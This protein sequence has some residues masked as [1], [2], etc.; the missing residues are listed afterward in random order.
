MQNL[1]E[2]TSQVPDS[3]QTNNNLQNGTIVVREGRDWSRPSSIR[4]PGK[5]GQRNSKLPFRKTQLQ[6]CCTKIDIVP[7]MAELRYYVD[8]ES[9]YMVQIKSHYPGRVSYI[10]NFSFHFTHLIS[11][12]V[13]WYSKSDVRCSQM[14]PIKMCMT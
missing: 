5:H 2:D 6:R 11:Y 3:S 4:G 9:T 10:N 13:F 8:N 1:P 12:L 14:Y 7:C